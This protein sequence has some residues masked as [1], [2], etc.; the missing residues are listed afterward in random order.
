MFLRAS[1]PEADVEAVLSGDPA[2]NARVEHGAELRSFALAVLA[3]DRDGVANA[4]A[5]VEAH[6]GFAGIV[7][8]AATVA[9]FDA[10]NRVADATGTVL[11]DPFTETRDLVE[12]RRR[13]G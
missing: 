5:V 11:E 13:P 7:D 9:L 6:L 4:A 3:R 1:E 12:A 8:A 10:I 2:S